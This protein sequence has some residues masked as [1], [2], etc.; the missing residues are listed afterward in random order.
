VRGPC[1]AGGDAADSEVGVESRQGRGGF[2]GGAAGG[3]ARG[4]RRGSPVETGE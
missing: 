1:V 4:G 3:K 2:G